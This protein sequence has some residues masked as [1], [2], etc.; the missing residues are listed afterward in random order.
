MSNIFNKIMLIH[1]KQVVDYSYMH[2][3]AEK[4]RQ[5]LTQ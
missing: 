4:I 1:N 3:A 5:L 2:A